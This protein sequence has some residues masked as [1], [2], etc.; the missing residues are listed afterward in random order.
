MKV[1][2]LES[3][4]DSLHNITTEETLTR[5]SVQG[6]AHRA[7]VWVRRVRRQIPGTLR[8]RCERQ[9]TLGLDKLEHPFEYRIEILT[10][11]GPR[12]ESVDL[13]ETFNML[14]G[15]HVERCESWR[16]SPEGRLYR[17]VKGR[18]A[19]AQRTLIIWR[20]MT[21]LDPAVEREFLEERIRSSGVFGE[22]WINGDSAVPGVRSLDAVLK[23]LIAGDERP[24]AATVGG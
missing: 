10:D 18:T 20:D 19:G 9:H 7:A 13:V 23:Q 8:T 11:A 14:Y 6:K 24:T 21:G 3:Y 1:V 5:A 15:I 17:V 12:T 22:V 16:E 2:R 4:E